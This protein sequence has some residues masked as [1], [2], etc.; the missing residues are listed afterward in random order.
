MI[1]Y[2]KELNPEQYRVVTEEGGPLL[3]LAGAGSGKTRTLTYRV[4]HLLES[5]IRPENILLATFTNKAAH[6][7]LNRVESLVHCYTGKIMGGTFHSIAHRFLRSYAFRLGYSNSFSIVD[8]EDA[9]QII[10]SAMAELKIDTKLTKFPKN[11]IIAEMISLMVNTENTLEEVISSR[12]PFFLHL[13]PEIHQIAC[14]YEQKKKDLC[15]MDFDDLL[16]NCRRLLREH[17]DILHT[18]SQRFEHVLVDEYQDTNIIQADMVDLLAS[19]HR[20]LMVVGDDS[21]SIYSFRGANFENIIHFPE[22]YPDC[23]IFKL[24]TNYRSTPEILHLANLSINNNENQFPKS[25]KAVRNKGMRPVIV[26]AQNVLKQADFVAQ[27]IAEL[28]RGGVPF[29]EI[30]VLYRAHYHSMEVQMEFVRRDIP[31]DIRSGIR[32][33]EQAHIKDVTSYMRVMV[34]PHDE[35]AWRRLMMMYPKI[36]KV[37]FGKIWDRLCKLDN[38]LESL[39]S[40]EY[41]KIVPK[42]AQIGVGQCRKTLL[43][44]LSL[45]VPDRTPEKII[46]LLLNKGDYR[47]YLQDNYSDASAREED[48][49]QLGNFAAKFERMDDFLNELALLT[50]MSK[51]EEIEEK[52]EDKVIL[53]TIHQAKGL[54][55]SYVFLIWCAD[56][57]IPLQRALNEPGG[58]EE[59]RR[60]FYVAVTRAKDQLYLCSPVLDY[61]RSAGTL[62]LS[63]SR[64]IR[65]IA[66][67]SS[68]DEQRP[69]EQWTLFD[70]Y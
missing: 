45:D 54:E 56:G 47:T 14:L 49:I 60:L 64:F 67:L 1:A 32:F 36:G 41:L 24:E 17:P 5:G 53:S 70:E 30:A 6:A 34:N 9:R 12:Y 62:T 23:K 66:P 10:A 26:S 51:E 4:A 40:E 11:N 27:R 52:Q 42:P 44:L 65:E 33:F 13:S 8:S 38:P 16:A 19:G 59:E 28:S 15:V 55:W 43:S 37:T 46:D 2:E 69:F 68:K 20:N 7:M 18:L 29:C 50:N 48:L 25:L 3:V 21:Q 63:P 22:R 61:T 58:E 31:F 57:M 35:L 39:L